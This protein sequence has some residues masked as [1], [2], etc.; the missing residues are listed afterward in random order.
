MNSKG[1]AFDSRGL[2]GLRC[3]YNAKPVSKA[4]RTFVVFFLPLAVLQAGV[5]GAVG[6]GGSG[7]EPSVCRG[8]CQQAAIDQ[9]WFLSP[10]SSSVAL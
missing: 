8:M 3:R 2:T 9:G 5:R 6:T 10:A 4:K 1:P 7:S